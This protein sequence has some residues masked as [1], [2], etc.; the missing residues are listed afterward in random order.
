MNTVVIDDH[1]V[2]GIDG[3]RPPDELMAVNVIPIGFLEQ[4]YSSM[5]LA[6]PFNGLCMPDARLDGT[7]DESFVG[8]YATAVSQSSINCVGQAYAADGDT[9]ASFA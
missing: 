6:S 2:L 8:R 5:K 4:D 9:I 7:L 3:C 1:L